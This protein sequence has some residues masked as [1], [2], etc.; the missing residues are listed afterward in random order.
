MLCFERDYNI[1]TFFLEY[2]YD[3]IIIPVK[4]I[5]LKYKQYVDLKNL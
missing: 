4:C 5:I 2:Y 1:K 3:F